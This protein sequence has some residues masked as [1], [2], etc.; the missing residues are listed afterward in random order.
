MR[1]YRRAINQGFS[2]VEAMVATALVGVGLT[3]VF[4]L[5]GLSYSS[6]NESIAREKLQI[7]SNQILNVIE[8]DIDNI[9]S[10]SLNMTT[11]TDPGLGAAT[12]LERQYEWCQRMEGEVGAAG[13]TNTRSITVT[14]M[15]DGSRVVH[16]ELEALN[17]NVQIVANRSY[18]AI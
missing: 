3:G 17:G 4:M 13:A 15:V 9:D 14:T 7:V 18:G 16:V 5:T 12:Y 6:L 10:Y 8:G 11:C 2:L 1:Q